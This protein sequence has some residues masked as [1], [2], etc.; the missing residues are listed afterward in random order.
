VT[1]KMSKDELKAEAKKKAHDYELQFHGCSQAVLL[2]LQEVLGIGDEVSF[3]AGSALCAGLGMSK[4][5]GT[6]T[7]G[8]MALSMKKGRERI[9]QGMDA[10]VPGMLLAQRLVKKFERE[11]NTT[12]CYE[13]T[14]VDWTDFAAV[15]KLLSDPQSAD[16]LERCAQIVGRTAE[17]V[18]EMINEDQ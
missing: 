18:V 8:V 16:Q 4:T 11:F 6:L 2:A 9:E 17:M 5:C 15:T 7:G 3:K 13:I 1:E 12:V 14:G 10:L